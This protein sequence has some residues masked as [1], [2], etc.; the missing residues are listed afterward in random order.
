MRTTFGTAKIVR[1]KLKNGDTSFTMSIVRSIRSPISG[2]PRPM[3]L[4]FI[5][6]I[7]Q[8]ELPEKSEAFWKTTDRILKELHSAN[9]I[10]FNDIEKISRR[11]ETVIPRPAPVVRNSIS[12]VNF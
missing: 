7:R 1:K 11:F 10:W 9:Q 3:L 4:R 12:S 5:G 6:T 2:Q 8:S